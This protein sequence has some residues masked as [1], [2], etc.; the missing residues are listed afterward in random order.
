VWAIF[1]DPVP[2]KKKKKKK[3]TPKIKKFYKPSVKTDKEGQVQWLTPVIPANWE[4]K[5]G[6]SW[7]EA[8]PGKNLAKPYL[9]VQA[10]CGS[11]CLSP[12]MWEA[13]VGGL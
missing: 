1:W 8:R 2:K 7:Y 4:A 12:A 11:T 13:K 6:G 3:K 10:G 5:A 9:K